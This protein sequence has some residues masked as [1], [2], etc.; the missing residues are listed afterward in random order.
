MTPSVERDR[1]AFLAPV[2]PVIFTFNEALTIRRVLDRLIAFDRVVVVDSGS[3]DG[4][5]EIVAHGD[6]KPEL[7]SHQY[8][9]SDTSSDSRFHLVASAD[10]LSILV[11]RQGQH[12]RQRT[13]N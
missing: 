10:P 3:D 2:T 9:R 12:S 5:I 7:G 8:S 13:Q 1:L 6:E 11:N 4:T